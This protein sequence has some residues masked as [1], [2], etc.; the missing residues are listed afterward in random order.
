MLLDRLGLTEE[1]FQITPRPRAYFNAESHRRARKAIT[2]A[3]DLGR[4]AVALIGEVGGGKTTLLYRLAQ[5]MLSAGGLWLA[6]RTDNTR[7]LGELTLDDIVRTVR[8]IA[9]GFGGI[10]L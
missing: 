2:S 5:D 1:P 7:R 9:P 8:L 10:N 4:P 3:L 6:A